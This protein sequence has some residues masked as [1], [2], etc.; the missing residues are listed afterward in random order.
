MQVARYN[1]YESNL[2]EESE[3]KEYNPV[4]LELDVIIPQGHNG[5][6][7]WKSWHFK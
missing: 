7:K 3:W 1:T 5:K 6:N 4:Y 2:W